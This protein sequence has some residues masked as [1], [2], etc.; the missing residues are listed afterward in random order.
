MVMEVIR[1]NHLEYKV[2]AVSFDGQTGM[3]FF[4]AQIWPDS[5]RSRI[6]GHRY[7]FNA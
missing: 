7:Q 1:V 6:L 2:G 4:K 3:G 5:N